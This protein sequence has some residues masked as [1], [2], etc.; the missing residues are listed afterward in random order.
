MEQ[1][2][3]GV[4]PGP[5][6]INLLVHSIDPQGDM[7]ALELGFHGFDGNSLLL[8]L[9]LSGI[10]HLL[11]VS[12][13]KELDEERRAR[14]FVDFPSSDEVQESGFREIL[15]QKVNFQLFDQFGNQQNVSKQLPLKGNDRSGCRSCW[16]RTLIDLRTVGL[17]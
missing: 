6:I 10:D 9:R 17:D 1:A 11:E 3:I 15:V 16:S 14:V 4:H 7:D 2:R 5:E 12:S 13:L 8:Y